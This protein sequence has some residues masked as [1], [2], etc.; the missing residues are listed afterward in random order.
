MYSYELSL[1]FLDPSKKTEH[2]LLPSKDWHSKVKTHSIQGRIQE[3][4]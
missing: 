3:F 4:V 1:S 2:E